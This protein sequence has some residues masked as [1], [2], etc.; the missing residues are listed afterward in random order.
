MSRQ[1]GACRLCRAIDLMTI[2]PDLSVIIPMMLCAG[3]DK[4][5]SFCNSTNGKQDQSA[6]TG[7]GDTWPAGPCMASNS[8]LHEYE[9]LSLAVDA[10]QLT[11]SNGIDAAAFLPED[12]AAPQG[13][14]AELDG[15]NHG[16]FGATLFAGPFAMLAIAADP[17]DFYEHIADAPLDLAPWPSVAAQHPSAT[18]PSA[19]AAAEAAPA[20][21]AAAASATAAAA[22]ALHER[23]QELQQQYHFHLCAPDDIDASTPLGEGGYATVYAGRYKGREVAVKVVKVPAP[24]QGQQVDQEA[25]RIEAELALVKELEAHLHVKRGKG[26]LP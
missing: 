1:D 26:V 23:W 25:L 8:D 5:S 21:A 4:V 20:A 3:A 6:A 24:Q 7:S 12:L 14:A 22:E 11:S 16:A 10:I 19:A 9:S 2:L 18:V 15:D 13:I 17:D